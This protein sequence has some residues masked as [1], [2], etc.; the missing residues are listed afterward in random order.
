M[1]LIFNYKEDRVN[2][3]IKKLDKK[4][5]IKFYDSCMGTGGWLVT[6]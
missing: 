5:K 3:I 4:E 6:G 1:K 2:E